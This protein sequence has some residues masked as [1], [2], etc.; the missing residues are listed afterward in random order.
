MNPS[1][2]LLS[3]CKQFRFYESIFFASHL[4]FL[5]KQTS[6][7]IRSRKLSASAFALLCCFLPCSGSYPSLDQMTGALLTHWKIRMSKSGLHERF[8]ESAV[9]FIQGVFREVVANDLKTSTVGSLLTAFKDVIVLDSTVVNLSDQCAGLFAGFGGGAAVSSAKIQFNMGLISGKI[10]DMRL[11]QGRS[12]D[13]SYRLGNI[14][15][16]ALYLF[17]LGYSCADNFQAIAQNGAWFLTRYKY[18][19]TLY[20]PN[21]QPISQK[22]LL[23]LVRR[24]RPGSRIDMNVLM[25]A[26][27]RTP[28]RLVLEKLPAEVAGQIRHKLLTDKQKK[29][30][31]L[32]Q[33]RLSFCN[34]SAFITNLDRTQLPAAQ[35][36]SVYGIRWQIE[37]LFKTWKS[38]IKIDQTRNI[39]PFQF[40]CCLYGAFIRIVISMRIFHLLKLDHWKTHREE[41]SELKAMN[42]LDTLKPLFAQWLF[43]SS[44]QLTN[45][46]KQI[47]LVVPHSCKKEAKKKGKTTFD[48]LTGIP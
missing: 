36:R 27:A 24:M 48:L 31:N 30:K 1:P 37:I 15:P 25:G 21:G 12:T 3:E 11:L 42:Y 16:E 46:L 8:T 38:F 19:T 4:D 35:I 33:E 6:F 34:V 18:K 45:L 22:A 14:L 7:I 40:Q 32:S 44:L 41:L 39:G 9:R 28:C 13:I 17:D 47:L 26:K 29:C 43:F 5:A 10:W 23:R 20:R 2:A